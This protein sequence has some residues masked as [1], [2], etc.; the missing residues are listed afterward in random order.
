MNNYFHCFVCFPAILMVEGRG[1]RGSGNVEIENTQHKSCF[2]FVLH[3]FLWDYSLRLTVV[4]VE[5][6]AASASHS[7]LL[8]NCTNKLL[9]AMCKYI[10]M[11][12]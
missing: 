6:K 4:L 10:R 3:I 12:E 9:P 7:D 11:V 2:L 8:T 5:T 1:K